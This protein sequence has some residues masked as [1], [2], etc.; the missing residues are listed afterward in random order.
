[1][2]DHLTNDWRNDEPRPAYTLPLIVDVPVTEE[3]PDGKRDISDWAARQKTVRYWLAL[4]SGTTEWNARVIVDKDKLKTLE[5]GKIY[6]TRELIGYT[7]CGH[8]DPQPLIM[9]LPEKVQF[10]VED[11]RSE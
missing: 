11:L 6:N 3:E 8:P 9:G 7:V 10:I 2:S 1:M 5:H 4:R